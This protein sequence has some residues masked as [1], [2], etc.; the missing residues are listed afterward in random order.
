M[1][2]LTAYSLADS[3]GASSYSMHSVLHRWSRLLS[4]G[5]EAVSIHFISVH[6]LGHAALSEDKQEYWK[7]DRRPLQHVLHTLN[8]CQVPQELAEYQLPPWAMHRLGDLLSRQGKLDKAERMYQRALAGKEKALGPDHTSTL[9]TV[10]NLGNLYSDQGKLDEAEQM[11]QRALLDYQR[12]YALSHHRVIAA[13]EKL[14]LAR[15]EKG[16]RNSSQCY[17]HLNLS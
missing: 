2:L 8:E 5:A 11:Y 3:L 15:L 14:A 12:I 17:P 6:T 9:N 10:N 4:S 13:S 1:G 16:K 7:L